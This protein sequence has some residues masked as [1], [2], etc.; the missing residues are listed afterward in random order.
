MALL[1][2]VE[3]AIGIIALSAATLR[4]LFRVFLSRS[5]LSGN[6]ASN[7]N[8]MWPTLPSRMGYIRSNSNSN[9]H[10]RPNDAEVGF[11][12]EL[13]QKPAITT[14]VGVRVLHPQSHG[15]Q[16]MSTSNRSQ[17][18]P[19]VEGDDSDDNFIFQNWGDGIQKTVV[20][21]RERV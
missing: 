21:A 17:S 11:R 14:V 12:S 10:A 3:V 16:C 19:S 13:E 15:R 9:Q 4:P 1:C 7:S 5:K 8:G 2:I 18:G 20:V 6:T